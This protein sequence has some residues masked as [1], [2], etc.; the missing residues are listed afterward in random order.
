[1]AR[2]AGRK[3]ALCACA[4]LL[5][6]TG[7]G[8]GLSQTENA[9]FRVTPATLSLGHGRHYARFT[10]QCSHPPGARGVTK[11]LQVLRKKTT[12]QGDF[13]LLAHVVGGVASLLTG[14]EFT[15]SGNSDALRMVK[16]NGDCLEDQHVY[17][18][19]SNVDG[20]L[21]HRDLRIETIALP[22]AKMTVIP[23]TSRL[24]AGVQYNITCAV[25]GKSR[26]EIKWYVLFQNQYLEMTPDL[27]VP[28]TQHRAVT[29]CLV[30]T[31]SSLIAEGEEVNRKTNQCRFV[32]KCVPLPQGL[33]DL[34]ADSLPLDLDTSRCEIP[35]PFPQGPS[36]PG[37]DDAVTTEH[38]ANATSSE[39]PQE[40]EE[41][42][43]A[44]ALLVTLISVTVGL[45]LVLLALGVL[46]LFKRSQLQ[47]DKA[48]VVRRLSVLHSRRAS[49]VPPGLLEVQLVG[50]PPP[51]PP[52]QSSS[53]PPSE[54]LA[55]S[56]TEAS[57]AF[58]SEVD[59]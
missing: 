15:V 41:P 40:L 51:P 37:P 28:F 4:L 59:R 9:T 45:S 26:L 44:R 46:A 8:P 6:A 3:S 24:Q 14:T 43:S 48:E 7:P 55:S 57:S 50:G 49:L 23:R 36:T 56:T 20:V 33:D 21:R 34:G 31:S 19:R 25:L 47:H 30:G 29:D 12:Q 5:L 35:R 16:E 22:K 54:S 2:D 13:Q 17:R 1:M 32:V 52:H 39:H 10:L 38:D 53:P 42:Q 58:E 27:F 18:C 11:T